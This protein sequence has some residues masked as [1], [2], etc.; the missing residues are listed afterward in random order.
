MA[1]GAGVV[2]I[3]LRVDARSIF[4]SRWV[5]WGLYG[6][7]LLLMLVALLA[8]PLVRNTH[9]WIVLGSFTL[10]QVELMKVALILL[11]A[12]YFSRR[13]M[14]IARTEKHITSFFFFVIP[15]AISVKLPDLGSAVIFFGIWFG[16]LLLLGL[17]LGGRS[18]HSWCCSS[19]R[20]S[21]RSRP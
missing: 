9:S 19:R 14:A 8:S 16:L 13:H 4:N 17:P 21:Y 6:F 1:I 5:V 12:N 10:P 3:F 11:Y 18:W 15:A 2:L 7:A 20:D